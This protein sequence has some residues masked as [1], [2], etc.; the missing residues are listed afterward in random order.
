MKAVLEIDAPEN[1]NEC[2]MVSESNGGDIYCLI[3]NQSVGYRLSRHPDCPL[4]IMK[5]ENTNRLMDEF[6]ALCKPLNEWLQKN[7]H[8]H[9]K[10]IIETDNAEV[11]EGSM[12]VPFE[13][14]D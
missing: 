3:T 11:V 10:I 12:A 2:R 1:C 6:K 4:K 7:Y 5:N 8:P 14:F 9:A 13:V